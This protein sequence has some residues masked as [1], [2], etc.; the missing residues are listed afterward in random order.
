MYFRSEASRI[1]KIQILCNQEASIALRSGS[2]DSGRIV[3]YPEVI[4]V[5]DLLI[6]RVEHS[7]GNLRITRETQHRRSATSCEVLSVTGSLPGGHG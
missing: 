5:R 2:D 3:G 6:G 7:L 1:R 4:L